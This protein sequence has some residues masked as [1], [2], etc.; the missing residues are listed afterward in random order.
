[1][2]IIK[3]V[4]Y[5]E[6]GK[7]QLN[8]GKNLGDEQNEVIFNF[9]DERHIKK[10]WYIISLNSKRK[11]KWDL[12]IIILVLW[13][14]IEVPFEIAFPDIK[15]HIAV[16]VFGHLIDIL[17]IADLILNFFTSYIKKRAKLPVYDLK[18]IAQMYIRTWRFYIDLL[19]SIPFD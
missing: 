14:C 1:V 3:K 4:D 11:L 8:D 9:K 13:N 2:G 18:S 6:I 16:N 17:F 12:L 7:D 19:A 5:K 10:P 15:L